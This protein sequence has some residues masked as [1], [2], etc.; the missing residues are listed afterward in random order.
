MDYYIHFPSSGG[1]F[2]ATTQDETM[3][4]KNA[5]EL[6]SFSFGAANDVNIGSISAGGGAGKATFK[7]LEFVAYIG[8]NTPKFIEK[9]VTGDHLDDAIITARVNLPGSEGRSYDL[10]TIELRLVMF[11]DVII[12]ASDGDVSLVQGVMQ[13]G[14]MKLTTNTLNA[15]GQV[16][17]T[18]EVTWSR[19]L[20]AATLDV[21]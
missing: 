7:E 14:A 15:Q 8:P 10:Y 16:S 19:V 13:F 17:V 4:D 5:I 9:L 21:E 12:E 1:E 18:K 3:K 2:I 20:N 11:Q 6:I